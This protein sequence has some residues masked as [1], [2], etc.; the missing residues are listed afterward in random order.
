MVVEYYIDEDLV[1]EE[2][3][4]KKALEQHVL[5]IRI[6]LDV[7]DKDENYIDTIICGLVS[8]SCNIDA[9]SDI[10]RT[11]TFVLIPLK[12]VNTLIEEDSLIWINRNIILSIGIQRHR[13]EEYTYYQQGK[14]LIQT[15][16]STYDATTNQLTLNCADWTCKL[17]GTKNGQLGA[18]VT[19]FPAYKEYYE[20]AED[21]YLFDWPI[22]STV[23]MDLA[24]SEASRKTYGK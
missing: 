9:N 16:N 18:L 23:S 21:N 12:K 8:G 17:D 20:G 7:Y 14:Y 4:L 19:S 6:K 15:Y 3:P 1:I 10:R 2:T 5:N 11:A 22:P 24:A 13:D